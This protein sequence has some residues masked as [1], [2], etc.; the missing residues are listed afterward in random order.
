LI[1]VALMLGSFLL[2]F[3][4]GEAYF[5]IRHARYGHV[6]LDA[7]LGWRPTPNYTFTGPL[8]SKDG[9]TYLV[10]VSQDPRGFRMFGDLD[11]DR[12]KLFVLGDSVTQAIQASDDRTYYATIGKRLNAEIFAYG[13]DGA[14]TLQEYM[15]LSKH[16]DDISPDLILWQY[17]SNDF[18]NNSY[19]LELNS[20]HN[21]NGLVRPY[22]EGDRVV[23]RTPKPY[24]KIVSFLIV[25]SYLM[26]FVLE[27]VARI[28]ASVSRDS[29]E[30][31][32]QR[33]GLDLPEFAQSYET[34]KQLM[35]MV[36]D[37][38]GDIPVVTFECDITSPK[39]SAAL[40]EISLSQSLPFIDEVDRVLTA[41]REQGDPIYA[42][43]GAHWNEAGHTLIG[44]T[45]SRYLDA[46][47]PWLFSDGQRR[48][49]YDF[50]AHLADAGANCELPDPEQ[51]REDAF[52]IDGDQR[53]VL[54]AHPELRVCYQ[55]RIDEGAQLVFDV[56]MAPDSWGEEGDGVSFAIYVEADQSSQ[57]AENA[58]EQLVFSKYIDP[59]HNEEDRRWDGHVV[60]LSDYA[61]Q[62][63][64][65]IFETSGGPE[66]D[67][68]Y[69]WA[70]WGMP[71][72]LAP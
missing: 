32:M 14:G 8:K 23:Y 35:D 5:R 4:V 22:L 13:T 31:E 72:L 26:R 25:R 19:Y 28:E 65:I 47:F 66:G 51:V 40:R 41:A 24:P 27:K 58:N 62:T 33:R 63:V 55:V 11:S 21:N 71:M 7:Q 48:M 59:K 54:Y 57:R 15:A 60:D 16:L 6:M 37:R 20:R 68:R 39:S 45:I 2:M 38:A 12:P 44:E 61:N 34:T 64:M 36:R 52:T 67:L 69:D 43:D 1:N 49:A 30:Q 56:A 3:A 9:T 10:S 29:I 42:A 70:G 17:C 50:L 18:V 46:E 53:R